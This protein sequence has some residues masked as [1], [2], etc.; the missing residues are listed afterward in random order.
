[1]AEENQ[2][3]TTE[4]YLIPHPE[5]RRRR[6]SPREG[7]F[8]ASKR[9]KPMFPG[10][11]AISKRPTAPQW[12]AL[13]SEFGPMFTEPGTAGTLGKKWGFNSPQIGF[14]S[15][16]QVCC[17]KGNHRF[18]ETWSRKGRGKGVA[19]DSDWSDLLGW[20]WGPEFSA[21]GGDISDERPKL[22]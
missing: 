12:D 21:G 14:P 9:P 10:F 2:G 6:S 15:P 8:Q 1:M 7:L 20:D 5:V 18:R 19:Q 4:H 3:V 11:F 13:K 17:P 22:P 16:P